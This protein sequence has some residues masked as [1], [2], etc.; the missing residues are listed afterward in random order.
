MAGHMGGT[1]QPDEQIEEELIE[2]ERDHLGHE[3]E[4]FLTPFMT[5]LAVLWIALFVVELTRGLDP[6]MQT[7]GTIIWVVFIIEFCIRFFVA[8]KKL[9]F[10]KTHWLTA[11]SLALPALRIF[12]AARILRVAR[13]TRGIRLLKFLGSA[14][15]GLGA[16]RN[17]L[18]KR[19][20][21]FVAL[22]STMVVFASAAAMMSFE[23]GAEGS[24]PVFASYGST[25]W[26]SAMMMT[27]VGTAWPVT[28]EG[29]LLAFLLALYAFSV[30]GY[31]TATLASF[32][33]GRDE[34]PVDEDLRRTLRRIEE[35]I[36]AI[37]SASTRSPES[38][39]S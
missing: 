38:G 17:H 29:R 22:V 6:W 34:E 15:R 24:D 12:R 25:L 10:V 31:V 18:S 8:P 11:L 36:A 5:L 7:A 35:R 33:I 21:G 37:E 3:L 39:S 4:R 9:H 30:F 20:A 14:N 26:W 2:K 16:L 1:M 13:V 23:R 32:F 28:T 27:T 19:N